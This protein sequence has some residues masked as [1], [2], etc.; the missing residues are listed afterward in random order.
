VLC[1]LAVFLIL[2]YSV[3]LGT[4]SA[5][6]VGMHTGLYKYE[7]TWLGIPLERKVTQTPLSRALTEYLGPQP[8]E[9][10]WIMASEN[11]S[12]IFHFYGQGVGASYG[13]RYDGF[14]GVLNDMSDEAKRKCLR[15]FLLSTRHRVG[16]FM[17]I[18]YI[19][20]M[21]DELSKKRRLLDASDIPTFD[22]VHAR[23]SE[24]NPRPSET[25]LP[26]QPEPASR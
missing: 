5:G 25:R 1:G 18:I 13:F 12:G 9:T 14:V 26:K 3:L 10:D 6:Y 16:D 21:E 2:A 4:Y 11:F 22:E 19:R 24:M 8:A 20:Y 15:E 23:W 17:P 7:L